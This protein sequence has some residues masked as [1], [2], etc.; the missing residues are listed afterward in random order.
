MK[1]I[2][3]FIIA[4]TAASSCTRFDID[5]VLLPREDISITH[6]GEEVMT[7]DP[8]TCQLSHDHEKNLY[9]VYNDVISDWFTVR[10]SSAPHAIGQE[11]TADVSWTTP[12]DT[13]SENGLTFTVEKTSSDGRIW[14]WNK[15]KSI[16]IVIKNL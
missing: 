4:V 2:L 1:K 14:M 15:S 12:D 10:C 11:I 13:K 8:L 7:Y 3:I 9:M 6:K 16:G 5:E